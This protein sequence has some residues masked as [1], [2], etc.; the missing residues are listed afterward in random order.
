MLRWIAAIDC[1]NASSLASP[2]SADAKQMVQ[3][4]HR[5]CST[6]DRLHQSATIFSLAIRTPGGCLK[7]KTSGFC[8]P[9]VRYPCFESRP[10][11]IN[12]RLH[13]TIECGGLGGR[14]QIAWRKYAF[15]L[16][17][18]LKTTQHTTIG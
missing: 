4:A 3:I 6:A 10:G 12:Q 9:L 1:W 13:S 2:T 17:E 15:T 7:T 5:A 18:R 14:R 16:E 8:R 11:P